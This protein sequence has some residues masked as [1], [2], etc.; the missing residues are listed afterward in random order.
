MP[1]SNISKAKIKG[2][3]Y[4]IVD[5][6]RGVANGVATLD[7][8]GHIPATQMPSIIDGEFYYQ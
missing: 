7:A 5:S 2:T 1:T 6:G 8:Q 4:N 3:T